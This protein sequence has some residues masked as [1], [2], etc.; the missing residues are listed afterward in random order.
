MIVFDSSQ[1]DMANRDFVV[2]AGFVSRGSQF[3]IGLACGRRLNCTMNNGMHI[4]FHVWYH[5]STP[6]I[7]CWWVDRGRF[8]R[9]WPKK[10]GEARGKKPLGLI[11]KRIQSELRAYECYQ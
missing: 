1:R 11:S 7:T 5:Q 4:N 10:E 9:R 3:A 2:V 8:E 6:R